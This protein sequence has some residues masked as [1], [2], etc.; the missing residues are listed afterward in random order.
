LGEQGFA[1]NLSR[2]DLEYLFAD[3]QEM[4]KAL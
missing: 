1:R 2:A 4:T 3:D